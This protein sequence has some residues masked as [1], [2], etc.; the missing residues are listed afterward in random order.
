MYKI[1]NSNEYYKNYDVML[2]TGAKDKNGKEIYFRDIV[3]VDDNNPCANGKKI[4]TFNE[5]KMSIDPFEFSLW[6]SLRPEDCIVV[7]NKFE[8]PELLK[9]VI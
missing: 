2:Y 6:G 8:T 9:E 1:P 5:E 3:E 4:I 7:G